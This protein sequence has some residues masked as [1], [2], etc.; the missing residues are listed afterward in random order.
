MANAVETQRGRHKLVHENYLYTF[1]KA[2]VDREHDIWVCEKRTTCKARVWTLANQD[3]VVKIVRGHN[4]AQQAARPDALRI[5]NRV[6][7]W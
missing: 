5:M 1:N 7:C 2:T 3:E 4:H 6:S